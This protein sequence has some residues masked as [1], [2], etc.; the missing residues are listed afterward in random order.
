MVAGAI[1]AEV[2]VS[3]FVA[4]ATFCEISRDSRSAKCCFFPCKVRRLDGTG[5]VTEAAGAR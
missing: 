4:G 2:G 1:F 3:L 5:K